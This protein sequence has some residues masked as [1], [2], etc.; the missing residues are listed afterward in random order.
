M[1]TTRPPLQAP[2]PSPGRRRFAALPL[3]WG[4]GLS[5]SLSLI[6]CGSL[7]PPPAPQPAYFALQGAAAK[8]QRPGPPRLAPVLVVQ[9]PR[10][11]PGFDTARMMYMRQPN[12][13]EYFAYSEWVDTPARML[14]PLM[15]AALDA[16]AGFGAVVQAPSL[17]SGGLQLETQL[18]RLQQEFAGGPSQ[19][20]LTLRAQLIDAANRRVLATRDF[21]HTV[22][23]TSEDAA[24][25]AAAA[26]VAVN[27]V[28]AELALWCGQVAAS[29]APGP[30][31]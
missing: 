19:L 21:E 23:S 3:C 6:G 10:A 24:G 1:T 15:V 25:G 20:R 4:L 11:A 12:R 7:L 29:A 13:L 5:L 26:Q 27:A 16:S 30:Q 17:V 9:P 31:R 8:A 22:P 28:L 2:A 14:A 18:L